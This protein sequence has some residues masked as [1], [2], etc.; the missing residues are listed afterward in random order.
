MAD[1][2][3]ATEEAEAKLKEVAAAAAQGY[4]Q[5]LLSPRWLMSPY[6]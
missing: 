2:K 6:Y 1:Q 3:R 5:M 4:H